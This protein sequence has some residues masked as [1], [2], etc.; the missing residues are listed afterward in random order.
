M[1]VRKIKNSWWIDFRAEYIR[2]RKRSPEN[3]KAGAEAYEALLRQKLARGEPIEKTILTSKQE[4]LFE[5]FVR[6][7]FDDYVV[8][9]NKYSEQRT[10]RYILDASLVPFFGKTLVGQITTYDIERYKA[11][12]AK[13]RVTNKTINNRLTVLKK[14]L[15]MAYEWLELE[16]VP[17]KITWL[18]CAPCRTDYLTPEE[19]EMLLTDR[20]SVV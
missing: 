10:K 13:S 6:R 18:K 20:K 5:R 3:S 14:C 1:S 15:T 12:T 8:S 19:C 2:Y 7:W 4:Q 16:G 17:P 11:H 9:N